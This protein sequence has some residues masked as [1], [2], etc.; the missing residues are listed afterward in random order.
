MATTV[1]PNDAAGRYEIW[2]DGEL[3]GFT[4][5][6]VDG[7][8]ATFPHTEISPDYEGRG[9]ATTLIR[10]ALDDMRSR[11]FTVVPRCPFVRAFIEKHPEYQD[12]V[13]R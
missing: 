4:Q 6:R 2:V 11:G 3:A 10:A 1:V 7:A 12:L 9:L 13:A 8:V 5:F